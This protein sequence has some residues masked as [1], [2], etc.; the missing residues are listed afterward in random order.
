MG[1]LWIRMDLTH[2][3]SVWPLIKTASSG[4]RG[5]ERLLAN[6]AADFH[7]LPSIPGIQKLYVGKLPWTIK[8]QNTFWIL[9][10]NKSV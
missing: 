3:P 9:I 4:I 5:L 10:G 2:F 7:P 8:E 6:Q 1:H